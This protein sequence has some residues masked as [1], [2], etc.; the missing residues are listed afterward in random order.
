MN[1]KKKSPLPAY[2]KQETGSGDF[3]YYLT[4]SKVAFDSK[5]KFI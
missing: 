1:K 5:Q 4:A 2:L 3:I